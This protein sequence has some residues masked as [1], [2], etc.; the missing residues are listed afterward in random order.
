MKDAVLLYG[1]VYPSAGL[2]L[3]SVSWLIARRQMSAHLLWVVTACGVLASVVRLVFLGRSGS[4]GVDYRIFHKAGLDILAGVSP[5]LPS[6][7][8]HHPILNQPTTYPI[9]ALIAA[10]PFSTGLAVWTIVNSV[11][12]FTVVWQARRVLAMQGTDGPSGLS[13][14][15]LWAL[16]TAF[17]LSDAC[18]ATIQ[19]GQLSLVATALILLALECQARQ[20]PYRAGAVLGVATMKV[21]TML[22]FLLLFTRKADRKSWIALAVTG[23][24]LIL[25]GGQASRIIEDL[26][27]EIGYIGQLSMPGRVNDVSYQGPYNEWILGI[28]HLAYR[29][30]VHH[31]SSLALIQ[32]LTLILVGAWLGWEIISRKISRVQGTVLLSLF[33]VIFLYHR[34]YDTVMIAP[35]LVY[36][37]DQAKSQRGR[38]RFLFAGAVVTMLGI[39]Y[40][41]R[42]TLAMLTVWVTTHS[43]MAASLIETL[44]LP[45]ATWLILLSIVLLRAA[46]ACARRAEL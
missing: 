4:L 20:E 6:R 9:F 2:A 13:N 7:F 3:F 36:A 46:I 40:M 5:Y 18:M 23:V 17:G 25:L 42:K 24:I 28:D 1:I 30:G 26:R 11:L 19:L 35:A 44:I 22:P 29:L 43:G 16:A 15:E 32:G 45:Y 33:S 21:S 14:A 39:L 8:T 41:R 38:C 37:V 27:L 10:V 31:R 12:A 34:L